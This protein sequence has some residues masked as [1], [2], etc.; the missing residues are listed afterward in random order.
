VEYYSSDNY[1][2]FFMTKLHDFLMWIM[3]IVLI[4]CHIT[5]D[6]K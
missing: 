2:M 3:R 4:D 6:N 5:S 1:N